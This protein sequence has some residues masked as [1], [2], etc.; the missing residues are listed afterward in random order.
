MT[1]KTDGS[2]RRSSS[3][4]DFGARL[5]PSFDPLAPVAKHSALFTGHGFSSLLDGG[6]D[7]DRT[8]VLDFRVVS[9]RPPRME[10]SRDGEGSRQSGDEEILAEDIIQIGSSASRV[11]SA[12]IRVGSGMASSAVD[13]EGLKP[14]IIKVAPNVGH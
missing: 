8:P 13:R 14:F 1:D 11:D 7:G 10:H 12:A 3:L 5:S 9:S 2:L 4:E 6:T